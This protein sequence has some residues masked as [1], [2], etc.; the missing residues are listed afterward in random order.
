MINALDGW[1]VGDNGTIL[2]FGFGSSIEEDVEPVFL[3][4]PNPGNEKIFI[5]SSD[6]VKINELSLF[7]MTGKQIIFQQKINAN[8]L[9]SIDVDG[10]S[11]GIY[12]LRIETNRKSITRKISLY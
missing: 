3:V 11:P 4:Y 9:I 7:D 8:D 6:Q 10:V 2:H 5:E 12:F 1:V